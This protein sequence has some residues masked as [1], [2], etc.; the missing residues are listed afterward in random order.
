MLAAARTKYGGNII[1]TETRFFQVDIYV[2]TPFLVLTIGYVGSA[3]NCQSKEMAGHGQKATTPAMIEVADK[4]DVMIIS[5]DPVNSLTV[6]NLPMGI[7]KDANKE[8]AIRVVKTFTEKALGMPTKYEIRLQVKGPIWYNI[9]Y[10]N[11]FILVGFYGLEKL[12]KSDD[13][14]R[15]MGQR[16]GDNIA[17]DVT[18]RNYL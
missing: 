10:E 9:T 18:W 15:V 2:C 8:A 5:N 1:T 17:T 16:Y 13:I 4:G 7:L 14:K 12:Q 6:D 3:L 11:W